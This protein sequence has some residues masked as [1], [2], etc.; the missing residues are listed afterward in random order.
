MFFI[1]SDVFTVVGF[2]TIDFGMSI[3]SYFRF[4]IFV[5]SDVFDLVII[6]VGFKVMKL[7]LQFFDG[8]IIARLKQNFIINFFFVFLLP[9]ITFSRFLTELFGDAITVSDDIG[10]ISFHL[11]NLVFKNLTLFQFAGS[12]HQFIIGLVQRSLKVLT[13]GFP[14]F[15][16][17]IVVKV[18][19]I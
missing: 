2:H 7:F 11:V 18:G 1:K 16:F 14:E 12:Q 15:G 8:K 13:S 17:L 6:K 3:N 9:D 19:V 4:Q 10:L 5:I